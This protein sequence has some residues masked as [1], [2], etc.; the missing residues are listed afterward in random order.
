MGPPDND[1]RPEPSSLF[2]RTTSTKVF[3]PRRQDRKER[4]PN[5]EYRNSKQYRTLKFSNN[6]CKFQ[7]VYD[8]CIFVI[9]ICFEFRISGFYSCL[10]LASFAP[11]RLA[12]WNTDSTKIELFARSAIPQG[13]SSF[14]H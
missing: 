6:E 9:W 11:L 3:A 2:I 1:Y 14:L 10:F 7:A 13:E 5:F 8:I 4:N 12:P